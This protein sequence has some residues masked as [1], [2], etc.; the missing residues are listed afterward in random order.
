MDGNSYLLLNRL[1]L[2]I[3]VASFH[4]HLIIIRN[5]YGGSTIDWSGF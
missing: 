5:Y 1:M 3:Y 2:P 4:S